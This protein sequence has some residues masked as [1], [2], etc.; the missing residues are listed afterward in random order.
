MP[1]P[2]ALASRQAKTF[3]YPRQL[4]QYAIQLP[5]LCLSRYPPESCHL[6]SF[7][8]SA[9][10]ASFCLLAAFPKFCFSPPWNCA[11]ALLQLEKAQGTLPHSSMDMPIP[12]HPMYVHPCIPRPLAALSRVKS[13]FSRF[14]PRSFKPVFARVATVITWSGILY[15]K[16]SCKLSFRSMNPYKKPQQKLTYFVNFLSHKITIGVIVGMNGKLKHGL[17]SKI[18]AAIE[19]RSS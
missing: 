11:L 17:E 10:D 19:I 13:C 16:S 3:A 9:S 14:Q 1:V 7:A 4:P 6:S 18:V 5:L 12:S 8:H 2:A 15:E